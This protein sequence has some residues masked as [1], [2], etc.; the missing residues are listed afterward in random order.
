MRFLQKTHNAPYF[1]S[2][3]RLEELSIFK[4][5]LAQIYE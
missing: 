5:K 2:Y 1:C 3:T 4:K